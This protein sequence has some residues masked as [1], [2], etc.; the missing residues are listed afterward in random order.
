MSTAPMIPTWWQRRRGLVKTA[1]WPLIAFLATAGTLWWGLPAQPSLVLHDGQK[2]VAFPRD[3]RAILTAQ[4]HRL[5]DPRAE[6]YRGPIQ[7][8]EIST[9]QVRRLPAAAEGDWQW[10][11]F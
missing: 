5:D 6:V 11:V 2:F 4:A 1:L 9:G 3:S 10:I 8:W 7:S